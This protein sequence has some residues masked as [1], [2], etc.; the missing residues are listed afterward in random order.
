MF[1]VLDFVSKYGALGSLARAEGISTTFGQRV[2]FSEFGPGYVS[3]AMGRGITPLSTGLD[4]AAKTAGRVSSLMDLNDLLNDTDEG[5]D[6][7]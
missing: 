2:L 1:K 7:E 4:Y 6:C 3:L 5:S